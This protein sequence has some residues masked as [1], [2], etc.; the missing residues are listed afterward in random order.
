MEELKP[1]KKFY[2]QWWFWIILVLIFFVFIIPSK[3]KEEIS[4]SQS[5]PTESTVSQ[6]ELSQP[7]PQSKSWHLI[8]TFK[9]E[10]IKTTEPFTIQGDRWR[11]N[12]KTEGEFNFQIFP[13]QVGK[14]YSFDCSILANIIGSGSDTSYCYTKGNWYLTIN[15]GNSWIITI[16]DYY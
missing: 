6:Q 2:K 8:T 13:N 12:W 7:I 11:V 1:K 14:E 10:G 3:K 5:Q 4:P 16:E 9:G 15:T